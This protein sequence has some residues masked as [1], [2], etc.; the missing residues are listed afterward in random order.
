M[1]IQFFP[2]TQNF[3]QLPNTIPNSA[4][5]TFN[6]CLIRQYGIY[7]YSHRELSN[8]LKNIYNL[9]N[10]ETICINS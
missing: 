10:E 9:L 8:Q 7:L 1:F 6:N 3:I 2:S 5:I 4:G